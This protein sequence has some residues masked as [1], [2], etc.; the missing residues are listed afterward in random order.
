LIILALVGLILGTYSVAVH[1]YFRTHRLDGEEAATTPSKP[2]EVADEA[3]L[4][5]AEQ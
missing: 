4:A 1:A 2:V 3:E 5:T